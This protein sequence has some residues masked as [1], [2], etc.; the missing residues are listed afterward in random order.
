MGT[1]THPAS[2]SDLNRRIVSFQLR[3]W[4]QPSHYFSSV[5]RLSSQTS[6]KKNPPRPAAMALGVAML[7]TRHFQQWLGVEQ[8]SELFTDIRG[9]DGASNVC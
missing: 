4:V 1:R 3:E 9:R 7:Y 6:S 2:F 5:R 8:R